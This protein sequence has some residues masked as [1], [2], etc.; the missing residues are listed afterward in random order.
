MKIHYKK[1]AIR[2]RIDKTKGS[3]HTKEIQKK[4]KASFD[5]RKQ[6]PMSITEMEM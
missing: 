5:E 6:T 2:I 3:F 4:T 1:N